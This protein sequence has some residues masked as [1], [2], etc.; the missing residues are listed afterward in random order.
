LN[1]IYDNTQLNPKVVELAHEAWDEWEKNGTSKPDDVTNI[2]EDPLHTY[3]VY[4][5]DILS[6]CNIKNVDSNNVFFSLLPIKNLNAY[7]STT[8]NKD[9]V[10]VFDENLVT[11]LL[12]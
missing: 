5:R 8:A 12:Q 9:K 2:A 10:I 11:F 1:T 7:A 3:R 6:V 4:Y